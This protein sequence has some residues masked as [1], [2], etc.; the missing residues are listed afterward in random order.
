MVDEDPHQL[1]SLCLNSQ[2]GYERSDEIRCIFIS[3]F[4]RGNSSCE[5]F[6]F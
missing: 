2:Q 5:N 6:V 4:E 3:S 1:K